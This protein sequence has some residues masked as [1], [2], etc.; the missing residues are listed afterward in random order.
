MKCPNC[1]SESTRRFEVIFDEGTTHTTSRSE[2]D[3]TMYVS[4]GAEGGYGNYGGSTTTETTSHTKLAKRCMPPAQHSAVGR[5]VLDFLLWI[6]LAVGVFVGLFFVMYSRGW[7]DTEGY[8]KKSDM[9]FYFIMLV[10]GLVLLWGFVRSVHRYRRTSARYRAD[11]ASRL[12]AWK[13]SWLC[14]AC[15]KAFE[16]L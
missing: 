16:S 13:R 2:S 12:A 3:G 11:F 6:V 15:G 14:L 7:I 9:L 1:G 8:D 4:S 10:A 5:V